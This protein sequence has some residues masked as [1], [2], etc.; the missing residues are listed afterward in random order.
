MVFT[1]RHR[2]HVGGRQ[3]K[4]C[5]LARFVCPPAFV[6]FIIVICVSRDCMKTTYMLEKL[7]YNVDLDVE[8]TSFI[9]K[10]QNVWFKGKDVALI[11]GYSDTDQ[12]L[13]KNVPDENKI[14]Q[15]SRQ[16]RETRGWSEGKK[17]CSGQPVPQTGWSK[18]TFI[19]EPGFYE[20][21]FGSKLETAKRSVIG[22]SHK[23]FHRSESIVSTNYSTT[24]ITK[25]LR[26]KMKQIYTAKLYT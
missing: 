9:D 11:L 12:A 21:V 18:T 19:S 3:T 7:F 24:R 25:C 6:H 15:L 13:T 22:Y 5:S 8:L 4:D 16:Q 2:R 1:L 17:Q 20:L 23:C 26:L 14:K 10:K